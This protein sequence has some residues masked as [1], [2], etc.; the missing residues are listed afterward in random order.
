V[1]DN[2]QLAFR[3]WVMATILA[4]GIF[5]SLFFPSAKASNYDGNFERVP[6]ISDRPVQVAQWAYTPTV[7]VCEHAPINQRQ[8]L[9]AVNLWKNLGHRFYSTQYKHDP[10]NKCLMKEPVGYIVVHMVTAGIRLEETSLAQTRFYIDNLTNK[11]LYAKIYMR[12]DVRETVLEHEIGH[13]LGYLHYNKINHLMN[14]K[15]Q[16]GGWDKEGLENKRQ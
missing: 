7:I 9:K 16:Q 1:N 12:S 15:W 6:L 11:I 14:E 3:G 10:M 13:A 5:G 4:V 8:I 2:E